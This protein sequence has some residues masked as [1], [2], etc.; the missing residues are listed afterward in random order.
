MRWRN[1][2]E[3]AFRPGG[4]SSVALKKRTLPKR[5]FSL[6]L[7]VRFK[8][9][10]YLPRDGAIPGEHAVKIKRCE[11]TSAPNATASP[12]D[13]RWI[14]LKIYSLAGQSGL[15]ATVPPGSKTFR[16]DLSSKAL[17]GKK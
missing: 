9:G 2:W 15:S 8:A 11:V 5:Q 1:P 12:R 16:F 7:R 17:P 4:S 14:S 6:W 13:V 10:T 3:T